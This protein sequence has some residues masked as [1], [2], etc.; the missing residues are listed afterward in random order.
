MSETAAVI[1]YTNHRGERALR[2]IEPMRIVFGSTPWHPDPQWLLEAWDITKNAL[3][4]FALTGMPGWHPPAGATAE[5][6]LAKQLQRSM[7]RNARMV[8]RLKK[9][10]D[11]LTEDAGSC[12][13][14]HTRECRSA[15]ESILKDEEPAW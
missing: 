4:S 13:E 3:R 10:A 9:L 12:A 8:N 7:E 14:E 2:P 6:S 15:L 1:D 11:K 5:A